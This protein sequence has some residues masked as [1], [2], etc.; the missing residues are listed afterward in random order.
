VAKGEG[1][2]DVEFE[3]FDVEEDVVPDWETDLT[4]RY[5]MNDYVELGGYHLYIMLG[6]Q[7]YTSAIRR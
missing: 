5:P 6:R 7:A 4:S 1:V 3:V 2:V